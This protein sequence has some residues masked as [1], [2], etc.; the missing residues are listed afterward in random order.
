MN[1]S[2]TKYLAK[3]IYERKKL[4]PYHLNIKKPN[5][6]NQVSFIVVSKSKQ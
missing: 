5:K 3:K 4:Q 6:Q 1:K 2:E